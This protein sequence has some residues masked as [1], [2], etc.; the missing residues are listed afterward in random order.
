MK[1]KLLMTN[2]ACFYSIFLG[3]ENMANLTEQGHHKTV[4]AIFCEP[5]V[6]VLH[7]N[8]FPAS[9]GNFLILISLHKESSLHPPS[10]LMFRCLAINLFSIQSHS[11]IFF[12]VILTGFYL[13]GSFN[14]DLPTWKTSFASCD[15]R[16]YGTQN[17]LFHTDYKKSVSIVSL[18]FFSRVFNLWIV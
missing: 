14:V 8:I 12:F 17:C 4:E 5:Y 13:H 3:L 10:K 2:S 18:Y 7:H 15:N 16:D 6:H 11:I 9:L 1:V